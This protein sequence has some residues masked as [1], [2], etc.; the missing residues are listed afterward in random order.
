M[1]NSVIKGNSLQIHGTYKLIY[2]NTNTH[3]DVKRGK[4]ITNTWKDCKYKYEQ[5]K[6]HYKCMER[7]Q[8]EKERSH[9]QDQ[10]AAAKYAQLNQAAT[11]NKK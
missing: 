11:K 2:G 6:V 7:W 5:E 1:T 9:L 10:E 3:T 8:L 4:F